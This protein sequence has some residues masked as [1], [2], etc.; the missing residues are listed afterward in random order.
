M[1]LA[2]LFLRLR[3]LFRYSQAEQELDEE[4]RAHLELQTRK[5]LAQGLDEAIARRRAR[6]DFGGLD[7]VSEE[8]R[9]ARGIEFLESLWRDVRYGLRTLRKSPGFT[10]TVVLALAIGIGANTALLHAFLS[11]LW[12]KLPFRE[13]ARIAVLWLKNI[14]DPHWGELMLSLPDLD[15]WRERTRS[16]SAVAGT[17]WTVNK[18]FGGE[19]P[20]RVRGFEVTTNI[21]DVLGL[22]PQFGRG[23]ADKDTDRRAILGSA[24]CARHFRTASEAIGATIRLDG[25]QYTVI[26]VLPR[27]FAIAFLPNP[28]VMLPLSRDS[29]GALDRQNRRIVGLARLRDGVSIEAA[30]SE[31]V[32]VAEQ[33]GREHREDAGWTANLNPLPKEGTQDAWTK[34]P[35]FAALAILIL[36]LACTNSAALSLARSLTRQPE[37]TVRGALGASR[38]RLV[39][40]IL[41][42][43]LL[44]SILAGVVGFFVALGGISLIRQYQPF[45]SNF[46]IAPIPDARIF[47]FY[48]LLIGGV[49]LL[50]G[51]APALAA[52]RAAEAQAINRASSRIVVSSGTLQSMAMIFQVGAAVAV[53]CITGLMGRTVVRLYHFDLGFSPDHLIEGEVILKGPRYSSPSAQRETF[54]RVLNSLDAGAA[55][56]SLFPLSQGYGMGGYRVQREDQP[57]PAEK[58]APS[59]TGVNAIS[60][61]Y[62]FTLGAKV[63][64][65][66]AF[67]AREHEPVAII[68]QTFAKKYFSGED[69]LDKLVLVTSPLQAQMDQLA[70]GPRRI[71]GVI[72]DISEN[73]PTATKAWPEFYVPFDQNPVPWVS[74]VV[75]GDSAEAMR[76]RV[77]EQDRDILVFRIHTAAELVDQAYAAPRF[78]FMMLGM[79][80]LLALFLSAVGIFSMVA[81]SVRRRRREFG[82]RLALGATPARIRRLALTG[83]FR[84][85]L[86]GLGVG[87]GMAAL[88]G[89]VTAELLYDLK[90]WDT[91]IAMA[92]IVVVSLTVA[93]ACLLPAR[94]AS[95]ADPLTA[96]RE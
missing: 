19:S 58:Q 24:F 72:K 54:N 88:L 5:Y 60:A 71:V 7:R 28:D 43:S 85:G 80:S 4:L 18:N 89:R 26:G 17:T 82:I 90:P 49:A 32:A 92:A 91:P 9:D 65:G 35:F 77:A 11:A 86:V 73:W 70:P 14:K 3:G 87:L 68:N 78:Q 66:R 2:D 37:M 53:L 10:A 31:M 50:F 34:L 15:D 62:F 42:E 96:V 51:S 39:Q 57:L 13:P 75:R 30:R 55:L 12:P 47:T 76:M 6:I 83:G 40:Q 81:H 74:I 20:E 23:F 8:C 61:N 41:C 95:R 79:F 94:E 38:G 1:R 16:F 44:V 21:F 56:T 29:V 33:L 52:S 46:P 22:Q 67:L 27:G 93:L 69:P 36:L 84:I 64:A 45:Y 63:I 48:A 25:E 59:M